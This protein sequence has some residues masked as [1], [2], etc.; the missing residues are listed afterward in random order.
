MPPTGGEKSRM[1]SMA[2][3]T[4]PVMKY[5]RLRPT[6]PYGLERVVSENHPMSGSV[7]TSQERAW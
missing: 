6:M 2:K 7:I 1:S 3:G 5:G 4:Q